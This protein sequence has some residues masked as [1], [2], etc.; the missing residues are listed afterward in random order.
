LLKLPGTGE[1]ASEE[2]RGAKD[3]ALAIARLAVPGP[4]DC[5][6]SRSKLVLKVVLAYEADD[7]DV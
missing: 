2:P 5:G 4:A 1:G 3:T 7:C 6:A